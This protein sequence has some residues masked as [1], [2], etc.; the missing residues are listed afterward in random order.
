MKK[1][2]DIIRTLL[3]ILCGISL[4]AMVVTVFIQTTSRNLFSHSFPWVEEFAGICMVWITFLGA[5]LTTSYD[6][7]TRIDV[8]LRALPK[9][10]AAILAIIGHIL[11]IVFSIVIVKYAG[12]LV[13]TTTK[14]TMAM[15]IPYQIYY[16]PL[17]I[18]GALTVIFFLVLIAQEI[19]KMTGHSD[20][21][22]GN[23]GGETK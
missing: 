6:S 8:L 14:K 22:V 18:G 13:N 20:E 3:K 12:V 15:H 17:V 4:V 11:C 21:T 23:E 7:H 2:L 16:Y 5:A 9:K 19:Q 10:I 1:I